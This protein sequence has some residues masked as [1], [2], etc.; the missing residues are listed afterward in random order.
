LRLLERS[1]R[2]LR[3]DFVDLW[4]VHHLGSVGELDR[5]C[6]RGGALEAL[7][8]MRDEGVVRFLGVTGHEDPGVLVEALKRF[9]FDTVLCALNAGDRHVR[10]SFV[11][12]L[13]PV[14]VRRR[15]GVVGMKV[16]AQGYIFGRSSDSIITSW[17]PIYYTLSLPVST[18]IVGCDNV[19]QL[20]E[21]VL[22]AKSFRKL[23]R[24][25]MLGIE[26]KTKKYVRRVCFFRGK[27][28]GYGS[29][30]R[31]GGKFRL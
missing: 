13:L 7:V 31:L 22:I 8:E 10:P 5:V 18:I 21:N 25:E 27:F 15:V 16:F 4:Q 12:T 26:G 17:E 30:K 6:G 14:A 2:R 3:T 9:G 11:D 23:S 19:A 20:E 24:A 29:K 1:L 28:G